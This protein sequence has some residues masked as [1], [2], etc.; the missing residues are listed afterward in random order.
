MITKNQAGFINFLVSSGALTFGEFTLK[1][2]RK[3]PYFINSGSFNTGEK[4]AK[5]GHFYSAH[6]QDCK[7]TGTDIIFGPAYKG[8]PLAVGTAIALNASG[9][10]CGYAFDRK[11]I[12]DH[13]DGGKTVG[14][15]IGNGANILIVEDVVTAG[16]T[17]ME[18]VPFLRQT[19]DVN[20]QGVVISVD[21]EERGSEQV[22][23]VSEM[24]R[25]LSIKIFPIVT[26]SMIVSYLAEENSSGFR[27]E[28]TRLEQ[29]KRYWAEYKAGN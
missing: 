12:K 2:G 4:I 7:I 29:I 18:V 6:I 10:N 27:L 20:I 8:I 14:M 11:E 28:Q 16:T 13:G 15:K 24:E 25:K 3:A 19:A 23:A 26:I 5:L 9:I 21:R 17:L 22:S 1:S